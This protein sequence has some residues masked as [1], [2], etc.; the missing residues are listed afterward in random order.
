MFELVRL[1]NIG[2][3]HDDHEGSTDLGSGAL[4]LCG[5]L[6]TIVSDRTHRVHLKILLTLPALL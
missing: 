3:R 2:T 5:T 6:S 4:K 1:S